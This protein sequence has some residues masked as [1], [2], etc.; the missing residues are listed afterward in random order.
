MSNRIGFD[1]DQ[2]YDYITYIRIRN[3]REKETDIMIE[4]QVKEVTLQLDT[5]PK[6]FSPRNADAGTLHMLDHVSF[7]P[8]DLVLDLGCG[9]GLVGI[10]AAKLIPPGQVYMTDLDPLAVRMSSVNLQKNGIQGVT[11][12]QGNAFESVERSDFTLILSNPPYHTDFAVAR[13]F[14]E[15]GFNRLALGG[16][17]YMV[18]RRKDW[19]KNKLISIFGGVRIWEEDGYFVFMAQKKSNS[20]CVKKSK[21]TR[22]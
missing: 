13:T 22:T 10:C 8:E 15:K 20:Y 18:T 2:T 3:V 5:D 6:L 1:K 17:L 21:K 7:L 12:T 14:I 9:Y 16:R 4:I 19:Y 11:L